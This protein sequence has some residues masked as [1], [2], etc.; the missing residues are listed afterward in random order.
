MS[1]TEASPTETSPR[2]RPMGCSCS[3]PECGES[4]WLVFEGKHCLSGVGR[5]M[6]LGSPS[7][8]LGPGG[9]HRGRVQLPAAALTRFSGALRLVVLDSLPALLLSGSRPAPTPC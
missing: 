7:R 2:G 6:D 8:A 5:S 4:R 3:S 9:V 1:P